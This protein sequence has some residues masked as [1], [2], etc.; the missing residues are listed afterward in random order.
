MQEEYTARQLSEILSKSVPTIHE[1]ADRLGW[2]T[3]P[4][5]NPKGGGTVKHYTG[6]DER[7]YLQICTRQT[8]KPVYVGSTLPVERSSHGAGVML[9]DTKANRASLK[10]DLLMHY[11]RAIK[12]AGY[13]NKSRARDDFMAAYNSGFTFPSIYKVLG[14]VSWQ[15]VETWK[16][17]LR[18]GGKLVDLSDR[19]GKWRRGQ[20]SVTARE[21]ALLMQCAFHPNG[22][23]IAQ[24]IH[25]AKTRL[26][27]MGINEQ[28]SDATYRRWLNSF[29]EH[30]YDIWCWQ[31]GGEKRWNDECCLAIDRDPDLINVGDVLVADGHKLN[32]EI[33]NPWTKHQQRMTLIVFYDMRSNYP[34]GWE[35]MPTENTVSISAAL[36]RAILTLG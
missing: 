24:V 16:R 6:F 10:A 29:K 30:N 2:K 28:R 14:K 36:R 20:S 35:I 13:G 27:G 4:R 25:E 1:M 15:T 7:I 23:P 18:G 12:S 19:R 31:R 11:M 32:F 34:C 9:S 8:P 21:A 26:R 17:T 33:F 22:W 5:P 3:T